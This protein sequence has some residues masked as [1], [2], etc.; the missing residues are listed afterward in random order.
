ML[1]TC[2]LSGGELLAYLANKDTLTEEECS[3]Y[4]RQLLEGL[5]YIHSCNII[6]MAIKVRIYMSLKRLIFVF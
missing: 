4:I 5:Q 2:S 3:H 1:S 6:H